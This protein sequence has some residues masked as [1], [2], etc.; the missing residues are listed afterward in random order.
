MSLNQCRVNNLLL[1]IAVSNIII[2]R[3]KQ[4]HNSSKY[5][6][7]VI[8]NV[9]VFSYLEIKALFI[10]RGILNNIL[11]KHKYDND[12]SIATVGRTFTSFLFFLKNTHSF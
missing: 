9:N 5:V 12:V 7:T 3:R 2:F 4:T 6:Y 1:I 11:T 10:Y 8:R